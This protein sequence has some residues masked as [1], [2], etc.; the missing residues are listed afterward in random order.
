MSRTI[1][2]SF[3]SIFA[4]AATAVAVTPAQAH[5]ECQFGCG[6]GGGLDLDLDLGIDLGLD[7][8]LGQCFDIDLELGA[9]CGIVADVD[10]ELYCNPLSVEAACYAELGVDCGLDAFAACVA[11]VTAHCQAEIEAGGALFCDGVFIGA[12]TCLWGLLDDDI[13]LDVDACFDVDLGVDVDI[14]IDIDLDLNPCIDLDLDADVECGVAVGLECVAQCTPLAVEAACI[15]KLG[16]DCELHDF[17][18]CQVE[19]IGECVAACDLDG[20]LF[21]GAGIFAGLDI[22]L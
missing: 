19:L 12:E 18:A 16:E 21:C 6:G 7:L 9:A 14:D 20:A 2:S 4:F 22:C 1:I 3:V 17:A 13:D 15:A 8:D 10:A 11:E 5:G